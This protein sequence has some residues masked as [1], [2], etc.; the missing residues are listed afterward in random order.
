[1]SIGSAVSLHDVFIGVDL[2]G[3]NIRVKCSG[4]DGRIL[5]E[6]TIPTVSKVYGE[7][8]EENLIGIIEKSV[9]S[10]SGDT[11]RV[12]AVGMGV[13]GIY[14]QRKILMSPNIDTI[15]ISR[16]LAHF[17][18]KGIAFHISND[19]KCA[20]MGEQWKG[21]ARNCDNFVLVN[22][23][24]GVSVA[25][26]INGRVYQGEHGAAGEIAYWI[27]DVGS[28]AGYG[29]GHVPL[30]EKF[31][32]RWLAE[33][34]KTR[35][36]AVKPAG[37]TEEQIAA[38][39]TKEIFAACYQGNEIIKD[40]VDDAVRHLATA[41]ANICV[42]LDPRLLVFSGG[43][44]ADLGYFIG[45]LQSYL[46]KIVPFPPEIAQSSLNGDAGI[47]GAI[48]MAIRQTEEGNREEGEES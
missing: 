23:G 9:S 25:T 14:Y 35:L 42:L 26:V 4:R 24:T 34:V 40:V 2:G 10:V 48:A 28:T 7:T 15:N 6:E 11:R 8:L 36:R 20:A 37:W 46:Q 44:T 41:L 12:L 43:I 18:R 16:L 39:T 21:I 27:S 30:E 5:H 31:S 38:I 13:P 19:V 29:E 33:N 1:M 32:G 3:T 17:E 22:I 47:Y 45:Y